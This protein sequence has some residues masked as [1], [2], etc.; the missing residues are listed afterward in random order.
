MSAIKDLLRAIDEV[1]EHLT[2]AQTSA[3]GGVSVATNALGLAQTLGVPAHINNMSRVKVTSEVAEA[4]IEAIVGRL[5][6]ARQIVQA[7][8]G[9]T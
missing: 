2:R 3:T 8:G 9:S 6:K 1:L 4:E 5:E 7:L